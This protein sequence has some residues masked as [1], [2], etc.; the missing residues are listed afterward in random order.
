MLLFNLRWIYFYSGEIHVRSVVK[1]KLIVALIVLAV[2]AAF[3]LPLAGVIEHTQIARANGPKMANTQST[4][5]NVRGNFINNLIPGGMWISPGDQFVVTS[6][7]LHLAAYA[8]PTNQGDPA[9]DHV[10][11]T[12]WWPGV[13]PNIWFIA[14][15]ISKPTPGTNNQYECNWNVSGLPQGPITVSFDVY[16]VVGN[17]NLAPNGTHQGTINLTSPPSMQ[18]PTYGYIGYLFHQQLTS[19]SA[20]LDISDPGQSHQGIDI[21]T[22]Q[23][24][25]GTNTQSPEG[26]PVWAAYEGTLI[27]IFDTSNKAVQ[28]TDPTASVLLIDNGLFNGVQI[29]TLYAHMANQDGTQSYVD[30]GLYIGKP[31]AQGDLLGHQ[32]NA[33]KSTNPDLITHLHF[34]IKTSASPGNDVDPSPYL[35]HQ[36]DRC[37]SDYPGWLDSFP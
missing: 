29:Y 37:N 13:D 8:Y 20:C 10:N 21:W 19:P 22:N 27:G 24:G 33:D 3:M 16:D 15:S 36:L 34:E 23:A 17:K 11:F 2:V 31:I 18:I 35:G 6:S 30:S 5:S 26:N 25:S 12:A 32:G 4:V 14:C 28:A 7:P 1:S 9:I